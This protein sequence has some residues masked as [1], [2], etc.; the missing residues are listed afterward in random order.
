MISSRRTDI[1][2][3]RRPDQVSQKTVFQRWPFRRLASL[4]LLLLAAAFLPTSAP[5]ATRILKLYENCELIETSWADGDSFLVRLPDDREITVRLYG[6]DC[7]ETK[8]VGDESNLRRLR[9]Q[10]KW[11]GIPNPVE[12][13]R[14]GLEARDV[15]FKKLSEPFSVI[16]AF[17]DARGSAEYERFYAFITTADGQDLAEFLVGNGLARAHGV[18][19]GRPDGLHRDEW[20]QRLEDLQLRAARENKGAWRLTNW[21]QLPELRQQLRRDHAEI[22]AIR[23]TGTFLEPGTTIDPN[24]ASRDELL[25][26]PGIGETMAF[27]IIEKRPFES[28]E[29]L[30]EVSGI[31][32]K[33]LENLRPFLA[34][35]E[36]T[37]E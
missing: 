23:E 29:D 21:D 17:A 7:I 6:V 34:I 2:E 12:A 1:R 8:L 28:I 26:L 15:V 20:E 31:G 3:G 27:R 4:L 13:R 10:S 11:F 19:R 16:T 35:G 25:A 18:L 5:A 30:L 36:A 32:P 14:I 22:R 37:E 24:T 9:D 33:T